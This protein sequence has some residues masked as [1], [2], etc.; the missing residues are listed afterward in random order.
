MTIKKII[1]FFR[2]RWK[3]LVSAFGFLLLIFYVGGFL[4]QIFCEA[5]MNLNPFV[6]LKE[7]M[8]QEGI[9]FTLLAGPFLFLF[10]GLI[11]WQGKEKE[12]AGRD[13]ERNF[14]YSTKGTYG[15]A[16][17][18]KKEE[19]KT[20]LESHQDIRNADG[21]IFGTDLEDGSIISLPVD[22]Y[23]NR[24]FAVCGSQGSMKS[25]AFARM[26]ALQCIKRGESVY[27]T[28]PKSELYEDLVVYLREEHYVCRRLNLIDLIHS[29]AWDCLAEIGD[30]GLID[31]FVDVVIRNTTDK[32]DHFYDNVEMDLLKALCLYVYEEYPPGRKTFPEAYNLLLNKSVDM[33][34]SIFENLPSSHPA[35]GPYRLFSKAEKV[36]GNAVLGLGTRLQ[37][38]QNKTV[39]KLTS[40]QEIDLSL[41]GKQK[42]A[43]FCITSD[44]D[45]TYNVL[46]TLF[47]SFL[48][49]KLVRL[50]DHTPNR[51]L[52]VPVHFIL[53]EFPNIG[54]VP[55]FTK[56]LAT[57]RSRGLGISI[58]YQNIPQ[59]Q[60]RYPDNQWEEILGGCDFS[61]FLGCNDIT[62]AEYFSKR[63][64]EITVAVDSV[65][66][67]YYTIRMTDYVPQYSESASVGKRQLLL[68][69][70]VLR[71]GH[72]EALLFIRGQK[73]LRLHK[74]DYTKH[75]AANA[76]KLE[77]T[78]EYVPQWRRE[79]N[80]EPQKDLTWE[81]LKERS[82]TWKEVMETEAPEEDKEILGIGTEVRKKDRSRSKGQENRDLDR[83]E[84][85]RKT[86][87][88][89]KAFM[90][91]EELFA[92]TD[93]GGEEEDG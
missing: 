41:P 13:E 55:D 17:F 86:A 65:R 42:C 49:I 11:I 4:K 62:T 91:V 30:G 37:I 64:G 88:R 34:D 58:L 12:V 15:T 63:S 56:K 78:T 21:V 73:M 50:A 52:P 40:H 35:K 57:A 79:E 92:D 18:M 9:T 48:C 38:L 8:S 43:Y 82:G 76:L 5:N 7:G 69:D 47:T 19:L 87:E 51:K 27:L 83:E 22:S 59:L 72:K 16:G 2:Q 31:V 1:G 3:I 45:S 28:D 75:P 6:C 33:L 93:K 46:A 70:E 39:Q 77:K 84:P 80:A 25:R 24:N 20:V 66:K 36:K 14:E 71:L 81:A 23:L 85:Q 61:L 54:V 29:D 32:F 67:N 53:D 10:G 26:M 89:G 60:N 44:Q 74:L 68:P 90:K